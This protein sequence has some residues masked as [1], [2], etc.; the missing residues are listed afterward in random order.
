MYNKA[1]NAAE[2]K[3]LKSGTDIR[4]IASPV[5]GKTVTLTDEYTEIIA[6]AFSVWLMRRTRKTHIKIAVGHDSRITAEKILSA[7]ER[8]ALSSGVDVVCTGLSSTPSMFMLL[9]TGGRDIDGAVMITASHLPAD[10]NGLKFFTCDG[11]LESE[12]IDD[13]LSIAETEQ[14]SRGFGALSYMSFMDEYSSM[15]ADRV[16]KACNKDRPLEGMKIIVDAGN[17]AGGFFAEKVLKP[18]GADTS[19]SLYLEPDGMFPHHVPNPEDKAAADSARAAVLENKADLGIVFDTDVDRAGA[20]DSDGREINRN[21]LIA[22]ISA[23]LLERRPGTI[24]TD[25]VT[26][27]GLKEFIAHLGG[28]QLRYKRGYRNVIDEC[29]RLNENGEYS[30]LAIETSGHAAFK[31]NYFLDDGAYLITEILICLAKQKEKG[32]SISDLIKDLREP[33][34]AAEARLS[35]TADEFK[36]YGQDVLDKVRQA[37]SSLPGA[38]LE[39]PNYEGVRINFESGYGSGWA[40][41]RMSLHEPI[42]PVNI[43]SDEKGGV[44]VIVSALLKILKGFDKLDLSPLALY[45]EKR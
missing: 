27:D 40:L 38:K 2:L 37:A 20:V 41:I 13:I 10:R 26:S 24:V 30:P 25:S 11:G 28:R 42:M 18:L 19:G 8:G 45:T 16:K 36:Q 9:K 31:D 4:G 34:E 35:I 44:K 1:M 14:F 32:L 22:L 5:L 3:K 6:R 43:E 33:E 15:L 21:R 29:K 17:G 12:D 7:F 23:I 39:Q